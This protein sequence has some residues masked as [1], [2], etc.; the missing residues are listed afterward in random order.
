MDRISR[1]RALLV[2]VLFFVVIGFFAFNLYEKQ[3]KHFC[4][5]LRTGKPD[6]FY[7]DRAVHVQA[8]VDELYAQN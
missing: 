8:L 6:Y 3:I 1:F 2:L 5:I 7:T 4:D